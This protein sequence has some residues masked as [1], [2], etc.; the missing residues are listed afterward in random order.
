[1]SPPNHALRPAA[2]PRGPARWALALRLGSYAL[3]VALANFAACRGTAYAAVPADATTAAPPAPFRAPY[4]PS[5][6]T[7][8]LQEVPSTQDPAVSEMK[9]LRATLDTAPHSLPAAIHLA[10][11][12]VDYGR[13]V[14]DAHYAGYG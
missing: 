5:T 11:A 12:Y 8:E 10:G 13:Q 1:M 3:G 14:G 4:L 9:A 6:D 2:H 7:E